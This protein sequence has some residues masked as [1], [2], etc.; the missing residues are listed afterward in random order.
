MSNKM[1]IDRLQVCKFFFLESSGLMVAATEERSETW[2]RS[3]LGASLFC[4]FCS[5]GA[6]GMSG[7]I[8]RFRTACPETALRVVLRVFSAICLSSSSD[9][10]EP[11]MSIVFR[12][13]W[14][15]VMDLFDAQEL[16]AM[17]NS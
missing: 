1:I 11:A 10:Y 7:A 5:T 8:G 17:I 9:R 3:I 16:C 14:I 13:R 6:I 15:G 12:G 4:M 2:M